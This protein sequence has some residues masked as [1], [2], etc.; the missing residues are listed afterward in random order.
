MTISNKGAPDWYTTVERNKIPEWIKL[1]NTIRL[2]T[3]TGDGKAYTSPIR[4]YN[5]KCNAGKC[6]DGSTRIN[7]LFNTSADRCLFNSVA[8]DYGENTC[9]HGNKIQALM[10]A[11]RNSFTVLQT[12]QLIPIIERIRRGIRMEQL[13]QELTILAFREM[14]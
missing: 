11:Q 4:N 14:Y 7:N 5:E 10:P 3:Y 13:E 12:S 2:Y 9:T 6:N 8:I 1:A